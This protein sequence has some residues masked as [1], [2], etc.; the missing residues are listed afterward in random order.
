MKLLP[1]LS[2]TVVA[3]CSTGPSFDSGPELA[4]NPNPSVP[5]A[6]VV[7]FTA[8]EAVAARIDVTDG[9]NE[10]TIEYDLASD[11]SRGLG[12]FGMRPDRDPRIQP[13]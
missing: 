2:M 3:G 10:W 1:L 11:P 9:S 13:T 4:A 7:R 5:L 8:S 12:V 6:A